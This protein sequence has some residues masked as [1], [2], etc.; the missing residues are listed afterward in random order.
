MAAALASFKTSIDAMS[1]GFK[2]AK[3][4]RS[5]PSLKENPNKLDGPT[6][7]A[8]FD[9]ELIITPSITYNGL[10]DP[11]GERAPRILTD[12]PVPG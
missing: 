5:E 9:S 1:F 2:V 3:G 7:A 11:F 12:I 6:L 8:L 10:F 4:L